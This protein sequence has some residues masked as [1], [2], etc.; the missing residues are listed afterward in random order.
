MTYHGRAAKTYNTLTIKILGLG[1]SWLM[2]IGVYV[3]VLR[4]GTS[5][6]Q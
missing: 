2:G 4:E 5:V 1:V 3:S 6:P